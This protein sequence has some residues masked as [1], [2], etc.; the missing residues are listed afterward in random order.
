MSNVTVYNP[1]FVAQVTKILEKKTAAGPVPRSVLAQA[2]GF[3][4]GKKEHV[5]S[6]LLADG[7]L[8]DYEA[9]KGKFGGIGRKGV[10][11]PASSSSRLDEDFLTLLNSALARL[12][13]VGSPRIVTRGD[14]G[15]EMGIPCGETEQRISLALSEGKVPGFCSKRGSGIYRDT[16]YVP[17][18][19][20]EGMS[21]DGEGSDDAVT[22]A[23]S[24][25]PTPE[26]TVEEVQ[27]ESEATAPTA[28]SSTKKSGKASAKK[29]AT[30]KG[31]K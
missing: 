30:K 22:E 12:I 29:T 31:K 16:S 1:E 11:R 6:D 28:S 20:E 7:L 25:E 14:V 2:F 15:R 27:G 26:P 8:P 10:S 4:P 23:A 21:A 5:F 19:P 17:P 13:P 3:A 18:T 9:V 24:T